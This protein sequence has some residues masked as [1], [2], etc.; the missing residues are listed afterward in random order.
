MQQSNKQNSDKLTVPVYDLDGK[1][2][3]EITLPAA[4]MHDLEPEII[5]RAV[6]SIQSARRQ[7]KGVKPEA[8]MKVAEYRGRRALPAQ[9]RG[10]NVEHARLPRLKNRGSLLASRVGNVP[11]AVGGR[12]AHP[13]KVEKIIFE[14]INKK[15]KKKALISAIAYTKELEHVSKR[16]KIKKG[17]AL[18]VVVENSIEGLR[19]TKEIV[20]LFS[21]IGL[22]ED[23]EYAKEKTKKRSGKGKMKG[24]RLKKK[25]SLLLVTSKECPVYKAARNLVGVDI[26]PVRKLNAEVLAPGGQPGRL[27]MWSE[28][29][30]KKV[31]EW[32]K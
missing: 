1:V 23:I 7:K 4:F 29:A 27:T 18:P 14:K 21:K 19:K 31:S 11:Q 3:K 24:R 6:L 13:P 16:H 12:A 30:I 15:E 25:K 26:V 10:I 20:D 8:G 22:L 28:D 32:L 2:V 17:L 5:R 9:N